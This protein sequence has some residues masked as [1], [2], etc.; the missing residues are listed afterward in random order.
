MTVIPTSTCPLL[1]FMRQ[2]M[3]R[4]HPY[5]PIAYL[6]KFPLRS[7]QPISLRLLELLLTPIIDLPTPNFASTVSYQTYPA[8]SFFNKYEPQPTDGL[9]VWPLHPEDCWDPFTDH[10]WPC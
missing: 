3:M 9:P 6:T 7:R 5:L 2:I 10:P 8:E 1:I 4:T